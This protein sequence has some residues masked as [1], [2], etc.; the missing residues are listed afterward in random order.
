M[1]E[2]PGGSCSGGSCD[3]N[4]E[5]RL[6]PGMLAEYD[7]NTSIADGLMIWL[8]IKEDGTFDVES[9]SMELLVKA[10]ET[11]DGRI[12]GVV[13]GDIELKPLYNK[14]FASGVGTI[15]HVKDKKLMSFDLEAYSGAMKEIAE[16]INPAIIIM[17]S[18]QRGNELATKLATSLNA[19]LSLNCAGLSSEKDTMEMARSDPK[20][21]VITVC[22]G[23]RMVIA[24]PKNDV[25]G[26]VIYWQYKGDGP[27]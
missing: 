2:C 6:P 5:C 23:S 24:E 16:R 1:G 12:F 20:I 14:I 21:M 26:T 8:E 19:K 10:R 11:Y 18:T 27:K 3:Q 4:N 13:F 7:L 9:S 17:S 22:A 15:Y 25:K